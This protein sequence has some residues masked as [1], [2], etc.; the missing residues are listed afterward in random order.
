M[1]REALE[2]V[3]SFKISTELIWFLG[4][5][6]FNTVM[7]TM[8][9]LL[10]EVVSVQI[11]LDQTVCLAISLYKLIQPMAIAPSPRF[12]LLLSCFTLSDL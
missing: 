4:S 7:S 10:R 6:V 12:H 3:S 8:L 5:S 2:G 1:E 11:L 9:L